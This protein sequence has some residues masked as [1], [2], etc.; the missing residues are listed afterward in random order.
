M[1]RSGPP[2]GSSSATHSQRIEMPQE[3]QP[4][5]YE[6]ISRGRRAGTLAD[7]ADAMVWPKNPILGRDEIPF[8][9]AAQ[10][11]DRGLSAT[12]GFAETPRPTIHSAGSPAGQVSAAGS[13]TN[14]SSILR[15]GHTLG[16]AGLFL[17]TVFVYVRPYELF[18][19]LA[20]LKTGA[21]WIAL[22]TLMVFVPTQLGLENKLTIRPREVSLVL[23][24]LVAGLLS[25]PLALEPLRAWNSFT[26]YLKVVLM[27]IV[28]VNVVRTERRLK[29]LFVLVLVASCV[30]SVSAVSD[31]DLGQLVLRGQRIA[32]KIGGLFE[33]PNDLALH[34][35]TMM[36]IAV[37]LTLGSRNLLKKGFYLACAVL[38]IAGIVVTF[39]R[40]GFLGM[41]CAGSVL[42]W[43][44]SRRN[45]LLIGALMPVLL[46]LIV[47]LAP[48]GYGDR[49]S[50]STDGSAIARQDDLRRSLFIAS[51][52]PLLGVGMDNYVLYSN[53]SHATHNA[54]TQVAAETGLVAAAI[55]VMFLITPLK[56]LRRVARES[57]VT[58]RE[59]GL[60]YLAVGLEASLVGYMVSSFFAS[61]A[62]LWYAYYLVAYAICLRRLSE[63]RA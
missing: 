32:G 20:W 24:L 29:A 60:Y 8:R 47:L 34:F 38:M 35:V 26:D 15:R 22:I 52:H 12:A 45:K 63:E 31:Y 57:S 27:F 7:D 42:V 54:Y 13:D 17:F 18:P 53:S 6:P 16:F 9:P 1:V 37:A 36:P 62:F 58:R 2:R 3:S 39:S 48:S 50:T 33:N 49:L 21:F 28:M 19:S 61:V 11:D 14:E 30:L 23:L 59:S 10:K 56:A 41:A 43:R 51:R 55:Y 5:D 40:G 25:I 44:F 4:L 46:V